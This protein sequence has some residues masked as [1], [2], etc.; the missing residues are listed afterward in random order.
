MQQGLSHHVIPDEGHLPFQVI[1]S[2]HK[3]MAFQACACA[4]AVALSF[5]FLTKC[6]C[7]TVHDQGAREPANAAALLSEEQKR[8]RC[9]WFEKQSC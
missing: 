8:D 1:N 7:E 9:T 5:L 2:K 3:A 6:S 4:I